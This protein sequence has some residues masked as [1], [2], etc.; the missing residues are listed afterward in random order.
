MVSDHTFKEQPREDK[1][2]MNVAGYLNKMAEDWQAGKEVGGGQWP[3]SVYTFLYS[4]DFWN[5]IS[6]LHTQRRKKNKKQKKIRKDK[7]KNLWNGV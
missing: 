4:S 6:V 7:E 1:P 2:N 3:F 5:N